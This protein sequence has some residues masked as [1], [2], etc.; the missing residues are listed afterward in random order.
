MNRKLVVFLGLVAALVA[1]CGDVEDCL[2]RG[3]PRVPGGGPVSVPSP[4]SRT[5]SPARSS[6]RRTRPSSRRSRTRRRRTGSFPVVGSRV[7]IWVVAQ[8]HLL[9][10]AFVLA[11]P[12]FALHRRGDRL[13]DRRPALRPARLRV[14]EAALGLVL[15]DG[16]VRRGPDVHAHHP[17]SEVHELPDERVLADV[18]ALRPAVLLRGLLPL[19]L[20]LRLG[21][22]P[23]AGAPRPRA[24]RSTSWARRS[25][26][27]PTPG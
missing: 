4:S 26:S 18:P 13:Q 14:H 1:E 22:I 8:L 12:I 20:L 2:V 21:E 6:T 10:A 27:S 7:A 5:A 17:V 11:V 15:A 9:F 23:S 16:D 24:R 19:H 3:G 25:C